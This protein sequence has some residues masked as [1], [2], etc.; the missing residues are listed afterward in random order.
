[1]DRKECRSL[2]LRERIVWGIEAKWSFQIDTTGSLYCP[3]TRRPSRFGSKNPVRF[4]SVNTGNGK[5]AY[6][7]KK[8]VYV[9]IPR[10]PHS[11]CWSIALCT[12]LVH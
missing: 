8:K 11:E 4:G 1:M 5:I 2:S 9:I 7:A 10:V 6:D 12:K 3:E